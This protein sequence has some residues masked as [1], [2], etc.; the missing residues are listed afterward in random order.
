M[1]RKY[2]A[3]LSIKMTF[4]FTVRVRRT[5]NSEAITIRLTDKEGRY[6]A[7]FKVKRTT[8]KKNIIDA[9][10]SMKGVKGLGRLDIFVSCWMGKDC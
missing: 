1:T 7:T 4:T 6:K 9:Y 3:I 10:V 8:K 5:A 2:G